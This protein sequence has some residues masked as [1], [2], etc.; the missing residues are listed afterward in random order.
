MFLRGGA[1]EALRPHSKA[2]L[3]AAGAAIYSYYLT[4]EDCTFIH[5]A[6]T[7]FG[8]VRCI[9]G[10]IRGCLFAGN[11]AE[12]ETGALQIRSQCELINCT[13]A[14]NRSRTWGTVRP[15]S[16]ITD[17]VMT[18][19]IIHDNLCFDPVWPREFTW[20]LHAMVSYNCMAPPPYQVDV[21]P[22]ECFDA[23]PCF[24]DPGYWDPNGT[25]DDP[26]DDFWVE[27]DYHLK[28]QAGRWD[29]NSQ[30][31]VIDDVT[32]P[33]IDTGDPN[34]PVGDE[35]FPNGGRINMGAYGGTAEASK[36]PFGE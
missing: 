15:E 8:A 26:N 33:C 10:D 30:S 25:P 35:P 5:N 34:S 18:N 31:W 14:G 16:S 13:F 1:V 3:G 4:L 29:A 22:V 17:I 27:G 32:S 12:Y 6:A 23:D 24:V 9:T 2:A 19:C 11:R 7:S 20:S 28:S 36:S 21:E